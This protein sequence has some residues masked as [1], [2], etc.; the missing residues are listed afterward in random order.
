MELIVAVIFMIS[1]TAC[2]GNN[3]YVVSSQT[4]HTCL[5]AGDVISDSPHNHGQLFYVLSHPFTFVMHRIQKH[6]LKVSTLFLQNNKRACVRDHRTP[7]I[8]PL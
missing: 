6:K 4:T 1:D 2:D 3:V 5:C 8:S 7:L